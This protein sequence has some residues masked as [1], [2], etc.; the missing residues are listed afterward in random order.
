M[1]RFAQYVEQCGS[2]KEWGGAG[3]IS[4]VPGE[5]G[6]ILHKIHVQTLGT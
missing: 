5:V 3:Q 6:A 4:L 1:G 2:A